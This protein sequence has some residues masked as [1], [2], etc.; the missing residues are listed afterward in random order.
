MV[1]EI[2]CKKAFNRTEI[3]VAEYSINPFIGCTHAC[4]YCYAR[5]IGSFKQMRGTWGKDIWVKVNLP[6]VLEKQLPK[7]SGRFFLSSVCD[8]YQHAERKYQITR[9]VLEILVSHWRDFRVMTKSVLVI[10]DIELL[11]DAEVTVVITTDSEQ[12]R[13]I[14]EPGASPIGERIELVKILKK[15]DIKTNIFVGPVLPMNP[16]N[17]AGTLAKIVDTVTLD[18]LNYPW[19]VAKIYKKMGWEEWLT[20]HKFLE[21]VHEFAKFL[22]VKW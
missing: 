13:G 14:L 12:V 19:L 21:V 16:R 18:R 11:R 7:A 20:S 17:L 15:H 5:F 1:Y 2:A 22:K 10:R 9:K 4:K 3:P 6:Q 8:P